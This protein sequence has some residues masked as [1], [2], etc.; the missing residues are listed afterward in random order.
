MAEPHPFQRLTI[1]ALLVANFAL[2]LG[3]WL[4]RLA[5]SEGGV[6]PIAAGFWRLTLALPILWIA[7][8]K[9]ERAPLRLGLNE[10]LAAIGGLAFAAEL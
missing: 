10:A 4:V 2:A 3:P 8:R 7:A 9:L 6:G 5:R 1:P